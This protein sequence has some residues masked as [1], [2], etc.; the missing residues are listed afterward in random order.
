MTTQ[1]PEI[2]EQ[3]SWSQLDLVEKS[4]K[5]VPASEVGEKFDDKKNTLQEWKADQTL[6][7][8]ED[9]P[10]EKIS[11]IIDFVQRNNA[12]V[13]EYEIVG[14]ADGHP[15]IDGGPNAQ[16]IRQ[17]CINLL[18]TLLPTQ[19]VPPEYQTRYLTDIANISPNDVLALTRALVLLNQLPKDVLDIIWPKLSWDIHTESEKSGEFRIATLQAHTQHGTFDMTETDEGALQKIPTLNTSLDLDTNS[20]LEQLQRTR[21]IELKNTLPRIDFIFSLPNPKNQKEIRYF[22]KQIN[23]DGT[24]K[25]GWYPI[26]NIT[27][28]HVQKRMNVVDLWQQ[29]QTANYPRLQEM[30]NNISNKGKYDDILTTLNQDRDSKDHIRKDAANTYLSNMIE[31]PDQKRQ[32]FIARVENA[33]WAWGFKML[34]QQTYGLTVY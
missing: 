29:T 14:I 8:A 32:Q 20:N 11:K 24:S 25:T 12:L 27:Y 5:W 17:Q 31:H 30:R 23:T 13:D 33:L 21:G 3:L 26:T 6:G 2:K 34:V 9:V 15:F 4:A 18:Q 28:G 10:Q 1:W 7:L 22:Q 16:A 19:I